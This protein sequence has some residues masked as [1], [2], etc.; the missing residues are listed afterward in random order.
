MD[1]CNPLKAFALKPKLDPTPRLTWN[2]GQPMDEKTSLAWNLVDDMSKVLFTSSAANTEEAAK[3]LMTICE[4]RWDSFKQDIP[5]LGVQGY[6]T[7]PIMKKL[8]ETRHP[9]M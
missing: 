4:V 2:P 9:W 3:T 5:D 8:P 1:M 6:M 7:T